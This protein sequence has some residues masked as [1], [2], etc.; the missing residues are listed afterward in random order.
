MGVF[1]NVGKGMLAG[2]VAGVLTGVLTIISDAVFYSRFAPPVKGAREYANP[3]TQLGVFM[4]IAVFYGAVQGVLF[5]WLLPVLP[6]GVLWRGVVFGLG[7]YLVLSRH[8]AEGFAF[9]SPEFMPAKVS[10]YL[11]VEFLTIYLLQGLL[12][13]KGVALLS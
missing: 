1:L 13:S 3:L 12:V 5:M 7:S 6:A 9:M 4:L 11:A 10:A 8:F 2:G